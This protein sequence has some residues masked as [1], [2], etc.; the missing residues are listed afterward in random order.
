MDEFATA[1][2]GSELGGYRITHL[3]G[4][5]G[6]A[7]V[8]AATN[9]IDIK[10]KR[11]LKVIRPHY[12]SQT[13]FVERFTK[14]ARLLEQ[15][16]SPY[17]VRFHGLR[18]ERG[19]L[20]MELEL[21]QGHDL[22]LDVIRNQA[23]PLDPL[24]VS[25]W[26]YQAALGLADAHQMKIVHR[27][28]KPANIFLCQADSMS[29]GQEHVK[30]LD[31]GVAKVIDELESAQRHTLDGH[32]VGSPAFM[33]PEVCEGESPTTRTDV[34]SLSLIGYQLLLGRHP[35]LKPQHK[36]NTMQVMLSHVQQQLP[37][38]AEVPNLPKNLEQVLAKGAAR[39]PQL[40]HQDGGEFARELGEVIET[41]TRGVHPIFQPIHTRPSHLKSVEIDAEQ[42]FGEGGLSALEARGLET[43]FNHDLSEPMSPVHSARVRRNVLISCFI[44]SLGILSWYV[45]ISGK[46]SA[47]LEPTTPDELR[48]QV[49]VG[50]HETGDD[51]ASVASR[52]HKR[53]STTM[54]PAER[55]RHLK[56]EWVPLGT[57]G[58]RAILKSE[59]TFAQYTLCQEAGGCLPHV[60]S[61]IARRGLYGACIAASPKLKNR[62][63]RAMNCLSYNDTRM[64]ADWLSALYKAQLAQVTESALHST[65]TRSTST[66]ST[67][68]DSTSTDSASTDSA[69]SRELN[70]LV[71]LPTR[72]Q[73]ESAWGDATYPWGETALSC[74][75]ATYF[76]RGPACG[77]VLAPASTCSKDREGE[78]A[79]CDLAGNVWEWLERAHPD[80]TESRIVGGGWSS[81]QS[82]LTR[83]SART[84][85]IDTRAPHIGARLVIELGI[86]KL[87]SL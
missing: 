87:N 6:M 65:S 44:L 64:F 34:Y 78:S 23:K 5:G 49:S 21:L 22:R 46:L 8:F 79:L 41:T 58:E 68:T 35:L 80:S 24:R 15:L 7:V 55:L 11:A 82:D 72:A 29:G 16:H 17:I 63:A 20:Y 1:L 84:E 86:S 60:S 14:E 83:D 69:P 28:M 2:I 67:S 56:L 4:D 73:W 70:G 13:R 39:D 75:R 51:H 57:G 43:G 53:L 9:T 45:V 26:L 54:S 19:Y 61:K 12:A 40:R 74:K 31:F 77:G 85:L 71:H 76:E 27:D 3:I 32:V 48:A 42:M 25:H 81:D 62:G 37:T 38:L 33:A 18:R 30:L 36:L 66:H 52:V 47:F 59:I 50:T 10:I